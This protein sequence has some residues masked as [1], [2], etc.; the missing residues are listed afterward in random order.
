MP[1][2]RPEKTIAARKLRVLVDADLTSWQAWN[3]YASEFADATGA[4][5]VHID[6]PATSRTA[7][8]GTIWL[9]AADPHRD[10]VTRS[11]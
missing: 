8:S 4:R 10:R 1:A 3:D 11:S 5:L 6:E 7:P 9:P 2:G